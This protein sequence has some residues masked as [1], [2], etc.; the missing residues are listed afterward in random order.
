MNQILRFFL[1][2]AATVAIVNCQDCDSDGPYQDDA[3]RAAVSAYNGNSSAKNLFVL[4]SFD[5]LC[6]RRREFYFMDLTLIATDCH[7]NA[8]NPKGCSR[9]RYSDV[10]CKNAIVLVRPF[11]ED[12]ISVRSI[13]NCRSVYQLQ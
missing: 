8:R 9:I 3:V 7:K 11:A 10:V 6:V 4:K 2:I 12:Q 13:G 1:L 5:S